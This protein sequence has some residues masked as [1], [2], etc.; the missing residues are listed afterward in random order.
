MY[1]YL[2]GHCGHGGD[3]GA[4]RALSRGYIHF[5][6]G[7]IEEIEV[8]VNHPMYC[9]VRSILKPSMKSGTYHTY[10]LLERDCELAII[11]SATCECAAGYAYNIYGYTV[12]INA[13]TQNQT[14]SG[15]VYLIYITIEICMPFHLKQ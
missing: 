8:N 5:A 1:S 11:Y 4:F 10:L 3:E 12:E 2:A 7:R 13:N 14:K 6:S 9:H 15:L